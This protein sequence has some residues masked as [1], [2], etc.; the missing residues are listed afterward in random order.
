MFNEYDDFPIVKGVILSR[1]TMGEN[2]L[3]VTLFLEGAGIMSLTSKDFKGDSEPFVWGEFY[4]R[5]KQKGTGYFI[6][7]TDI[8]DCMLHIRRGREPIETAFNFSSLLIKYLPACHPDDELLTNLYWSMKLLTV[9]SVPSS[10]VNWRF[11]WKWLEEWGIAPNFLPFHT[12]KG[13]NDEEI[14]L[15][16][17]LSV[18]NYRG[19]IELFSDRIS[20]NVREN[21]FKVASKL[22]IQ[23]FN[24][25]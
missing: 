20:P 17:K 24:E 7:D 21:I 23:F 22:A 14:I 8:K 11:I 19:V 25:K 13:F 1:K 2:N 18:M 9:P 3:W 12:A 6:F 15:L 16:S 10:A 5:K 4:L